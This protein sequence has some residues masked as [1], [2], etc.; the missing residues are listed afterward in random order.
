LV[1]AAS[2]GGLRGSVIGRCEVMVW[3]CRCEGPERPSADFQ[4]APGAS[5]GGARADEHEASAVKRK[6]ERARCGAPE[7]GAGMNGMLHE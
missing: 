4:D 6:T 2:G 5:E 1:D 7:A 3:A